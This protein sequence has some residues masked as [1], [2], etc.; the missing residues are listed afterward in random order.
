MVDTTDE[1]RFQAKGVTTSRKGIPHTP[2]TALVEHCLPQLRLHSG[3]EKYTQSEEDLLNTI[4]V[5]S[6]VEAE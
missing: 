4:V 3:S 1:E 6:I 5:P 2:S